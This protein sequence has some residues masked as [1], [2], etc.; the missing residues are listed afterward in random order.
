M[1]PVCLPAYSI[2]FSSPITVNAKLLFTAANSPLP[3]FTATI[4]TG[5]ATEEFLTCAPARI[6]QDGLQPM[7]LSPDI[8][9]CHAYACVSMS[10]PSN[11]PCLRKRRH[12]TRPPPPG[13]HRHGVPIAERDWLAKAQAWVARVNSLGSSQILEI[14]P[15]QAALDA[16]TQNSTTWDEPNSFA[17]GA[18]NGQAQSN[19]HRQTSWHRPKSLSL[20]AKPVRPQSQDLLGDLWEPAGGRRQGVYR[21]RAAGMVGRTHYL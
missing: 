3:R 20:C 10:C 16:A 1:I 13:V 17:R 7:P 19:E 2:L 9:G 8:L 15:V 18:S 21:F 11:G 14:E 5:L 12:G 6:M 4:L